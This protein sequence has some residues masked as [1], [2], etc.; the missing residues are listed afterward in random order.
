MVIIECPGNTGNNAQGHHQSILGSKD[1]L[2]NKRKLSYSAFLIKY[3][4][5]SMVACHKVYILSNIRVSV[6]IHQE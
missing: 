4:P 1:K 2:S 6:E 5:G 3:V